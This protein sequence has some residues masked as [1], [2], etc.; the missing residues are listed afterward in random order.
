MSE[1]DEMPGYRKSYDGTTG[2]SWVSVTPATPDDAPNP[3]TMYARRDT[4]ALGELYLRHVAAMTAEGLY[5]K[6]AIAAELAWRDAEIA[7][8]KSASVAVNTWGVNLFEAMGKFM[9]DAAESNGPL[10]TKILCT[11]PDRPDFPVLHF[12]ATTDGQNPIARNSE[13]R[14]QLA[15]RDRDAAELADA[16]RERDELRATL[17]KVRELPERIKALEPNPEIAEWIQIPGPY[18][19]GFGGARHA[20]VELVTAALAATPRTGGRTP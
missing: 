7:R 6:G 13:L 11:F 20:A 17:T 5:D 10:S 16:R 1:R 18:R 12:W 15:D 14:A 19:L 2:E 3:G 9:A 4:E 8:L